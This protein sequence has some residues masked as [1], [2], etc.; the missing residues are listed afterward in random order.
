MK[1]LQQSIKQILVQMINK[2]K[3]QFNSLYEKSQIINEILQCID[4]IELYVYGNM[5][6]K[7]IMKIISGIYSDDFSGIYKYD[8]EY[9]TN[10]KNKI[11][12]QAKNIHQKNGLIFAKKI[13]ELI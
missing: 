3:F 10:I 4:Q 1:T 2:M 12:T 6:M 11:K 13:I 7:E 5:D 8:N 9:F